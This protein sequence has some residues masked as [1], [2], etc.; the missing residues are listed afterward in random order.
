MS[1]F[2]V[3]Y[4]A[5]ECTCVCVCTCANVNAGMHAAAYMW[6]SVFVLVHGCPC[7]VS[8]AV[9]GDSPVFVSHVAVGDQGLQGPATSSGFAQVLLPTEPSPWSYNVLSSVS[10]S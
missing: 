1:L 4:S 10:I 9:S 8:W 6:G 7:P 5:F 2:S 3:N